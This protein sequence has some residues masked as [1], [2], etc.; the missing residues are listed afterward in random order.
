[1]RM[2]Y[3]VVAG[4]GV[5]IHRIDAIYI[6]VSHLRQA[7]QMKLNLEL[8]EIDI[9]QF[10]RIRRYSQQ[11]ALLVKNKIIELLIRLDKFSINLSHRWHRNV[12]SLDGLL[13]L[14]D[15]KRDIPQCR[16]RLF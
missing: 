1:M 12:A 9:V 8:A 14:L 2:R 13:G 11:V 3:A 7:R 5:R 4:C 10:N 6:V 15:M 16:F